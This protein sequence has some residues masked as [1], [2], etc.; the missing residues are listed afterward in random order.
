MPVELKYLLV[1]NLLTA[2]L[3]PVQLQMYVMIFSVEIEIIPKL[4]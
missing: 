1:L 4:E 3:S 2:L